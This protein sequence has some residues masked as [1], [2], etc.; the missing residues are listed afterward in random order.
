MMAM[1]RNIFGWIWV[2]ALLLTASLG[3]GQVPQPEAARLG[4]ELK[5]S[6]ALQQSR[7]EPS[8]ST[9]SIW[10]SG[11]PAKTTIEVAATGK[12]VVIDTTT[13]GADGKPIGIEGAKAQADMLVKRLKYAGLK[14]VV[15][16]RKAP[17][18][19]LLV[20]SSDGGIEVLDAESGQAMWSATVGEYSMPT[21]PAFM[22]DKHVIVTNGSTI[23]ALEATTGKI[24]KS[25]RSEA[26]PGAAAF[27]WNNR[28]Y[29]PTVNGRLLSYELDAP[30]VEPWRF[31][32]AG[33]SMI[34]T[35]INRETNTFAV[36]AEPRYA[37]F[38][39][40]P[41][42][43]KPRGRSDR[44]EPLSPSPLT[45][46]E[47]Q[48]QIICAP[49]A[50]KDS[51]IVCSRSG[52]IF[53]VKPGSGITWMTSTSAVLYEKPLAAQDAIFV[54]TDAGH[55]RG[56]H[57]L[58]GN[59]LPGWESTV[60]L[61][62]QVLAV[63][64]DRVYIRSISGKLVAIEK[65]TGKVLGMAGDNLRHSLSN[66]VTDRIYLVSDSGTLQCFAQKGLNSPLIHESLAPPEAADGKA[67]P[68]AE[69]APKAAEPAEGDGSDPFGG[70]STDAGEEKPDAGM[71]A[72]AGDDPFGGN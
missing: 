10:Q 45:R 70:S 38:F 68:K 55:V 18:I 51:F 35:A 37:Y 28:V 71:N 36:P 20:T 44:E 59:L 52:E 7:F 65:D 50:Y 58:T 67:K 19:F 43:I 49:I 69:P 56:Y 9:I 32:F 66:A 42:G 31:V 39:S 21:F 12:T 48:T 30:Y 16:E 64:N 63:S 23:Y 61:A 5:W 24:I 47:A 33:R 54:V 60:S 17:T 6:G 53:S 72:P 41:L 40:A 14:P 15:S 34:P 8:R 3:F 11:L 1:S 62:E 29:I 13:L 46:L 25:F 26:A 57:A 27:E 4:L 22:N 2:S